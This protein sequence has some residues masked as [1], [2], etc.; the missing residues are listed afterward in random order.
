MIKRIL[1]IVLLFV[2]L[3]VSAQNPITPAFKTNGDVS[4]LD[5]LGAFWTG[6]VGGLHWYPSIPYLRS[7]YLRKV[8]SNSTDR[9]YITKYFFQHNKGSVFKSYVDSLNA[10]IYANNH[11]IAGSWSFS[12]TTNFNNNVNFL[13]QIAHVGPAP[14]LSHDIVL[15]AGGTASAT[16][17]YRDFLTQSVTTNNIGDYKEI[18]QISDTYGFYTPASK[19]KICLSI[20]NGEIDI[21]EVPIGIKFGTAGGWYNLKPTVTTIVDS[22]RNLTIDVHAGA[23]CCNNFIDKIRV[24]RLLTGLSGGAVYIETDFQKSLT[25]LTATGNVATAVPILPYAQLTTYKDDIIRPDG[26]KAFFTADSA[27]IAKKDSTSQIHDNLYRLSDKAVSRTNLS[28]YSKA[29]SDANY[30]QKVFVTPDQYGAVGN[31]TTDDYTAFAAAIASG[32]DIRLVPGK[33]YR[34]SATLTFNTNQSVFGQRS[35]FIKFAGIKAFIPGNNSTF[36]GVNFLGNKHNSS[37]TTE[38][39][40]WN[41]SKNNVKITNCRADSVATVAFY[42]DSTAGAGGVRYLNTISNNYGENNTVFIKLGQRGEYNQI[43]NN[44]S[45]GAD[46]A[47][48]CLG[49]NNPITGGEYI[50]GTIGLYDGSDLINEGHTGRTGATFNHNVINLFVN[51]IRAIVGNVYSNCAFEIGSIRIVNSGNISI[52]GGNITFTSIDTLKNTNSTISL[53]NVNIGASPHYTELSGGTHT[54]KNNHLIYASPTTADQVLYQSDAILASSDFL[55]QGTTVTVLHGNAS[56]NP[57]FGAISLTADVSGI[58]PIANGGT[59]SATQ[60]FVDL[61]TNQTNIAGGKTFQ[62]STNNV[63]TVQQNA[64]SP[65]SGNYAFRINNAAQNSN[66][67]AAGAFAIDVNS[68]RAVTVNGSGNTLIGKNL[69]TTLTPS[70]VAGTDSLLVKNSSTNVVGKIPP[71]YYAPTTGATLITVKPASTF[72]TPAGAGTDSVV[73]KNAATGKLS[74]VKTLGV[75]QIDTANIATHTYTG[76]YATINGSPTFVTQA[77]SDNSTKVA[78]TAFVKGQLAIHGNSTTT[79]TATTAVTV[80]IGSTMANTT[81]YVGIAPQD[82]LTAVNWY[83]SAKTTTTFTITFVTALTGSINFDFEIIP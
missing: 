49:G 60:N 69:I 21:Y 13:Y 5:S 29:Q 35:A 40:V 66:V 83:I 79:G 7:F 28:V 26:T 10:A 67:T 68:G 20:N 59:G 23:S 58:T 17:A 4:A 25:Y 14:A 75:S 30:S 44:T 39:A 48:V 15:T 51:N 34:I 50:N 54:F 42:V 1:I 53:T 55:N 78:T 19:L 31:G 77:S 11:T 22:T 16:S 2:G 64:T 18:Y 8:D 43:N 3:K 36:D 71:T 72:Q 12:N 56:G 6:Q 80:T 61:T 65:A 33:T 38:F 45:R 57:S 24:R 9:N 62:N 82:L 46:T 73:V 32:N 27:G 74:A 41:R 76:R 37:S 63:V 52:L 81:Y 47:I 70:G